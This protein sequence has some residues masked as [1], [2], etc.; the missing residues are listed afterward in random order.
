MKTKK[1]YQI[2]KVV[3]LVLA[4]LSTALG[5]ERELNEFSELTES[6]E[7][8]QS[9]AEAEELGVIIERNLPV[10]IRDTTSRPYAVVVDANTLEHPEWGQVVEAVKKKYNAKIFVAHYPEVGTVRKALNEYM[11][12]YV[13]FVAQPEQATR[14]MI[15][16]A[17]YT[18]T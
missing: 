10:P 2:V 18:M 5:C 6:T 16:A 14:E 1:A 13:C 8:T 15:T 11:P 9:L 12:W 3:L 7:Q 4:I 17:A